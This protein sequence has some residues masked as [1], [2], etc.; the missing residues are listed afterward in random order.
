MGMFRAELVFEFRVWTNGKSI[1][2]GGMVASTDV[3][4]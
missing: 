2:G 3:V 4:K 1:T